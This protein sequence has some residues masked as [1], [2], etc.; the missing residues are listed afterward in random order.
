[1]SRPELAPAFEIIFVVSLDP[2]A[3]PVLTAENIR[4]TIERGDHQS[5]LA[6]S[7]W[8]APSAG[9]AVEHGSIR[10]ST[11]R[12]ALHLAAIRARADAVDSMLCVYASVS[13]AGLA[14]EVDR[15]R[16]DAR[17]DVPALC[18][19]LEGERAETARLRGI[20]TEARGW[21]QGQ[22]IFEPANVREA[23]AILDRAGK[24]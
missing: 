10:L 2:K 14:A 18:D 3:P 1:M 13:D 24:P 6:D 8:C 4:A 15:V 22:A 12:P 16:D 19:A 17:T 21:L 11:V 20:I 9:A 7:L 23:R 5:D